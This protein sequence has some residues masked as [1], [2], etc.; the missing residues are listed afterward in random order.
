MQFVIKTLFCGILVIL[1]IYSGSAFRNFKRRSN[2][3]ENVQAIKCQSI[4][5]ASKVRY[6]T[7]WPIHY[8]KNG[9]KYPN[10]CHDEKKSVDLVNSKDLEAKIDKITRDCRLRERGMDKAKDHVSSVANLEKWASELSDHSLSYI[11]CELEY[12]ALSP[13]RVINSDFVTQTY[14]QSILDLNTVLDLLNMCLQKINILTFRHWFEDELYNNVTSIKKNIEEYSKKIKPVLNCIH[15]NDKHGLNSQYKYTNSDFMNTVSQKKA[16]P[17]CPDDHFS[18]TIHENEFH[19]CKIH[20]ENNII[21]IAVNIITPLYISV[22]DNMR[23]Y[24]DL[25]NFLNRL[26]YAYENQYLEYQKFPDDSHHKKAMLQYILEKYLN[27]LISFDLKSGED[28]LLATRVVEA[29]T[30]RDAR[31]VFVTLNWYV[32]NLKKES[33]VEIAYLVSNPFPISTYI[34]NYSDVY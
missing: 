20:F 34:E 18:Q 30:R 29:F 17:R 13:Y 22:S 23:H 9:L 16:L 4:Y 7:L 6:G 12:I 33:D 14:T 2:D 11:G 32:E 27:K 28:V 21:T 31:S 8:Y 15:Q 10:I 26:I 3:P 1:C 5:N 24:S 25:K 19:D